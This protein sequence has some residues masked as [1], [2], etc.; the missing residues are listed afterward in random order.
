[1][2]SSRIYA[3]IA[4]AALLT[5][6]CTHDEII[7]EQ[8]TQYLQMVTSSVTTLQSP[9]ASRAVAHAPVDDDAFV[10]GTVGTNIPEGVPEFLPYNSLYPVPINKEF[11]TVGTFLAEDARGSY[12]TTSGYFKYEADNR[13]TSTVGIKDGTHNFIFGYMPSN[14]GT[15]QASITKRDDSNTWADG[16]K[17]TLKNLP[18][19]TPADVCVVVGVLKADVP[20]TKPDGWQPAPINAPSVIQQLHQGVYGYEGTA[21]DNYVYLLL[22]HIYA[23]I[24]VE[25]SVD[26]EYAKLRNIVLKDVY[27]RTVLPA[28]VDCDIEFCNDAKKPI[29]SIQFTDA[30][31]AAAT[32]RARLFTSDDRMLLTPTPQSIPVYF[33]PYLP[34]SGF[35]Y[36]FHYDVYDRE[37][38]DLSDPDNPKYGN[39]VRKDCIALNHWAIHGYS[40]EAGLSF[41][42]DVKIQPTYLFM[43]SEP[44]LD[45][46][47]FELK[48]VPN[49]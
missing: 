47:T 23:N 15:V 45:N 17:M 8:P 2:T 40:V 9:V 6:S 36:E 4:L 32:T 12:S 3:L 48:V 14:T 21:E 7:D 37:G 20:E 38:E 46:P 49:P 11:T 34:D 25:L 24:N 10:P 26:P 5:A 30:S 28:Q 29:K 16:A 44:D 22:E 43:L 1:M 27:V 33:S 18:A 39:L 41:K 35:D 31:G 42:A 13:W 19:A